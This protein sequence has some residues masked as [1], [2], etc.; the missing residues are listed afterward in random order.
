LAKILLPFAHFIT[1]TSLLPAECGFV[2]NFNPYAHPL[3][4]TT[5]FLFFLFTT[6]LSAQ[7]YRFRHL[8]TAEGLLSDLR[9][10]M[11]EDR[12]GRLWIGSEEG[13]NIYD[14]YQLSTFNQPDSLF[15]YSFNVLQIYCDKAGTIWIA[16]NRGI[17][18]KKET[19]NRF[20]QIPYEGEIVLD[21]IFFGELSDG[22]LMIA[23]KNNCVVWNE[24]KSTG[25]AGVLEKIFR[26]YKS[27]IS[28]EH[29]KD[30]E[31]LM[32]FRSKLLLV[33]M[34]KQ[35][36]LK[37]LSPFN[38]WC[39]AK[40]S[41]SLILAGSFA[42]DTI[43]LINVYSGKSEM[44]N[45]WTGHDGKPLGGYAGGIVSLG[46]QKFAL[47]SRYYGLG[48]I[49]VKKRSFDY[50]QHDPTDPYSIKSNGVRRLLVT[51]NGTLFILTRG[52]S[53]VQLSEPL[54][55]S[56]KFLV[57]QEGERYD[58]AIN[59]VAEDGK[60]NFWVATNRHLANWNR[61]TNVCTFFPYSDVTNGPQRY[62]TVRAVVTDKLDRVWVGTFGGGIGRLLPDGSFKQFRRKLN[63]S[64]N[65]LPSNDVHA[66]TKDAKGNFLVCANGGFA[67]FDPLSETITRFTGHPSLGKVA[68]Q[69]TFYAMGDKKDNWWL[70]QV[71]GLFF[72]N[73]INSRIEQIKLPGGNNKVQMQVIA[74]DSTGLIYAG[75]VDGLYIISPVTLAVQKVLRK[76]QG[77]TSNNIVG[78]LCDRQGNMWILGNIGVSKYN[79]RTGIVESFDARDGMEQSNHNLCNFYLS[80]KGEVF[81]TSAEGFNHFFPEKIQPVRRPLQVLITSIELSDTTISAPANSKY[82]FRYD[83]NNITFSYLSV[84]YK[85][86]PS[87][88]YRYKLS[89][90]DTGYIYA[91]KQRMAR[92]TNLS[93]GNYYFSAEASL[94]GYDWFASGGEMEISIEKAFWRTGWFRLLLIALI[95]LVLFIVYSI[96]IN[97]IKR[98]ETLKRDFENQLA[99]VRMNLLRTQMNPHFLFNSLN[100]INS[101]ILK[102]DRQ[103]ASGYLTKFSRLMRIIL[104]NSRNEWVTL[105]RELKAIELYVQ[106]E[107]LRFNHSFE[108]KM[109][110]PEALD[111]EN[112]VLPPMLIQPYIEN[113]IWHGLMYRKEPGGQLTVSVKELDQ[114]IEVRI[115]D[116]GVGRAAAEAMKSKSALQQKSY[117]MKITAERMRIVNMAY[118][119]DAHAEVIDLWDSAA[120]P[121]GTEVVLSLKR[122]F[123]EQKQ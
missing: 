41:D 9:L 48:I 84:D 31:W 52:L 75:G 16:T 99:Q 104:D 50:L 91:G 15:A 64:L 122:I 73:S 36:V 88:T 111:A 110:L 53:F 58:G 86:G 55:H 2:H 59:T 57:N 26:E 95:G 60:G 97:K 4:Q 12:Q 19:Q 63:D 78:L 22:S 81:L 35:K 40:V 118:Q 94:N 70:A 8:T 79:P 76:E 100:S 82:L 34:K 7:P 90:F 43:T 44:V 18:F 92:Y 83:Q 6:V 93:A 108:Y 85:L 11:A 62:R 23:G 56:Q 42:H 45:Q 114:T 115:T 49:D 51:R 28:F 112:L 47:A 71:D 116:N 119:I 39:T 74:K 24:S 120:Q 66:I 37:E 69:T 30:D 3:K 68:S 101:F 20:R 32:G 5:F 117:G 109:T 107:S 38:T 25:K 13:I 77:L 80:E 67:L 21:G 123:N 98:N 121:A 106:L 14:G 46:K 96:R 87:I 1:F 113:A 27:L 61:Q 102:N 29:F 17:F 65:S 10:V 72:F 54:F 103:N 105:E 89:G 33:N